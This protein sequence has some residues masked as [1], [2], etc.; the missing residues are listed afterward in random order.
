M[1]DAERLVSC[2]DVTAFGQEALAIPGG[3]LSGQ[4]ESAFRGDDHGAEQDEGD[5]FTYL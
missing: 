3:E 2:K 5:N 4:A 1:L